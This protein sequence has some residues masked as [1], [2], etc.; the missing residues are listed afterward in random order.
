[1]NE[2]RNETLIARL[3][4]D[5]KVKNAI[6]QKL[7]TGYFADQNFESTK[8]VI[9]HKKNNEKFLVFWAKLD[10]FLLWNRKKKPRERIRMK[11]FIV[12]RRKKVSVKNSYIKKIQDFC[13]DEKIHPCTDK[14]T[15]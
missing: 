12:L 10:I 5:K 3:Q 2:R 8:M 6:A 7:K 13:F 15:Q 9:I 4:I 14:Y 11:H 1:M